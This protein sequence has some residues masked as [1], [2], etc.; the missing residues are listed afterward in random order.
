MVQFMLE[1]PRGFNLS[2]TGAMKTLAS[3]WAVDALM[4]VEG[5]RC[6]IVCPKSILHE[7]WANEIR[8]NFL[9]RRTFT[10]L[11]GSADRRRKLLSGEFDFAIINHDGVSVIY[12]ELKSA[13]FR[14]GI[15]DEASVCCEATT[16]R[17]KL[18]RALFEN[19]PYFWAL[20]G[21]PCSQGPHKAFGVGA[22]VNG[23]RSHGH[24]YCGSY[25][26][27]SFKQDVMTLDPESWT[28]KWIPREDANETVYEF[29]QPA[30]RFHVD[31]CISLPSKMEPQFRECPLG[32]EQTKAYKRLQ[33]EATLLL[34]GRR[35]DAANA[36]VLKGKLL[37][38]IC[39]G[40][41]DV[42]GVA[43]NLPCGHR[44]NIVEEIVRECRQK[45]IIYAPFTSSVK[46]LALHFGCPF[47]CG[48]VSLSQRNAIFSEFRKDTGPK[49]IVCDPS[50]VQH[51]L[52]LT[53]ASVIIWYAPPTKAEHYKQANARPYRS[54]QEHHLLIVNIFSTPIDRDMYDRL[55]KGLSIEQSILKLVERDRYGVSCSL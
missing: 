27:T 6:L 46:R 36:A 48:E 26:A 47:I 29:L 33:R 2:D 30:I 8:A 16:T 22:L 11:Y 18:A 50:T 9:G 38:I 3:L 4:S 12:E 20:T 19:Y 14:Y 13:G 24:V 7:V 31:E 23:K 25:T 10:V 55:D 17:S 54:G 41:Y 49:M 35:I 53:C 42:D 52:N 37:Q 40:V 28:P 15:Y 34:D 43:V 5:G 32:P 21:S 45:V 51:G 44:F 39:G 1:N